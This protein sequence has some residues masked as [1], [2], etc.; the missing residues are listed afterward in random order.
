[1]KKIKLIF[2]VLS[3]ANYARVKSVIKKAIESEIIEPIVVVGC[4]A[5]SNDYGNIIEECD[6]ENIVIHEKISSLMHEKTRENIW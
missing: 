6:R 5:L 2:S 3:R 1:M 4:S